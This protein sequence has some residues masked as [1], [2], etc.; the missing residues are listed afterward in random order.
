MD[1]D[2]QRWLIYAGIIAF[3]LWLYIYDMNRISELESSRNQWQ[4]AWLELQEV[5][6]KKKEVTNAGQSRTNHKRRPV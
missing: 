2:F 6:R 4:H 5:T 1:E 3:A